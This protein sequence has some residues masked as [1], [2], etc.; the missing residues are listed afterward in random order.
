MFRAIRN[1]NVPVPFCPQRSRQLMRLAGREL[2]QVVIL[3][4][5]VLPEK[6]ELPTIDELR[7]MSYQAMLAGADTVSF[8]NYDPQLWQRTTGFTEG[9]TD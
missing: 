3:Q 6:P 8:Y 2:P 5:W 9:F 7:V 1:L 4:T